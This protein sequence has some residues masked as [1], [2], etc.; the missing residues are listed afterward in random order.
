MP[1][2]LAPMAVDH[3]EAVIDIFNHYVEHSF[4]AYPERPLPYPAF[5]MLLK[6]C[7]GYPAV[8]AR[9]EAGQVM[10]FGMLRAHNPMPTFAQT[11]EITYFVKPGCT[12]Q[13]IGRQMLEH[14]IGEARRKDITT[15][16][17]SI[18]ALNEGSIRFHAKNGFVEC[19]RFRQVGRKKGQVFDVVWMQRMV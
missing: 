4:A 16:L 1:I 10:G 19:G 7:E 3:R 13:G 15:I 6:M 12:G 14:M 9:D 18:S 5:D 17:A 8:V 2:Q 11:A